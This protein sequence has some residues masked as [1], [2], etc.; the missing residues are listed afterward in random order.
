MIIANWQWEPKKKF[1]GSYKAGQ[2]F[3]NSDIAEYLSEEL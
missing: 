3:G 1:V 2:I